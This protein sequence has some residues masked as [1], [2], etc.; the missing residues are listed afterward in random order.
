MKPAVVELGDGA[1]LGP[2]AFQ[3]A[4]FWLVLLHRVGLDIP[5]IKN[6]VEVIGITFDGKESMACFFC[7]SAFSNWAEG[8]VHVNGILSGIFSERV[9]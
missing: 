3:T 7:C 8:V 4:I 1:I 2:S 9:K 5:E 6:H